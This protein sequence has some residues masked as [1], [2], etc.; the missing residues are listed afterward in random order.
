MI[1]LTEEDRLQAERKKKRLFILFI[2]VTCVF[3]A[4]AL[5]LLLRST[6]RYLP[7]MIADI[8]ITVAYGWFAVYFFTVAYDFAV[9]NSRFLDR[10]L[11]ALPEKEYGIFLREEEKKTIDGVEMRI[12]LFSIRETEREVRL[13]QGEVTFEQGKKYLL[14]MQ[15]GVLIALGE[16]DE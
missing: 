4:A 5:L 9:K 12:F 7:F 2:A 13:Y 10:V 3:V 8:V 15:C 16:T 1:F 11:G 6:D 14:K